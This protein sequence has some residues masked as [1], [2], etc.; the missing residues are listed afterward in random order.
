MRPGRT[1]L[2]PFYLS[3]SAVLGVLMGI[4]ISHRDTSFKKNYPYGGDGFEKLQRVLVLI[5]NQY[6]EQ[7]NVDSLMEIAINDILHRLDPHSSFIDS[8]HSG[9]IEEEI[10]GRYYGAGAEFT[11]IRD[12]TVLLSAFPGSPAETAGLKS[13][14]K[15]MAIDGQNLFET[16]Y[17][18]D[19]QKIIGLIKNSGRVKVRITYQRMGREETK[20]LKKDWISMPSV[21]SAFYMPNGIAVIGIER[22][23]E[24][25]YQNFVREARKLKIDT[26]R[27]LILDLRDNPGGLLIEAVRIAREF[28][29]EGDTVVIVEDRNKSREV[30]RSSING[31]Y[32]NIPLV[33]LVNENSASASEVLAGAIQDNARGIIAGAPTYGKGLVQEESLLPDGSRVRITTGRYYTPTGR[34]IQS[35]YLPGIH[36]QGRLHDKTHISKNGKALHEGGG[37]H[38][39]VSLGFKQLNNYSHSYQYYIQP[40]EELFE[41]AVQHGDSLREFGFEKFMLQFNPTFEEAIQMMGMSNQAAKR[42]SK[43]MMDA[44]ILHVKAS[45]AYMI[46]G[47][48]YG[49]QVI[50]MHD[51]SI[52][53]L[54]DQL[55]SKSIP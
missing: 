37:I 14:D 4:F 47:P 3:I 35:P 17:R 9:H 15:I 10:T 46:F 43:E 55:V 27:G 7:V 50:K 45:L 51:P 19:L 36:E 8:A 49:R 40:G 18:G 24:N 41:Y 16:P 39:D 12:T 38:P 30:V 28:L 44:S 54:A 6:V 48:Q 21:S 53:M 26:A 23:S 5:K 29:T 20:T 34:S 25:T 32:R 22:F 42:A 13:G 31:R 11:M 2:W 33:I 1:T 52:Q